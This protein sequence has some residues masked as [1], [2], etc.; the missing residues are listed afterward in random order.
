MHGTTNIKY[1]DMPKGDHS[2]P[3]KRRGGGEPMI[4]HVP[5][6]MLRICW[7]NPRIIFGAASINSN[8]AAACSVYSI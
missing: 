6:T 3:K 2:L 8:M 5:S 1:N 7:K 4:E